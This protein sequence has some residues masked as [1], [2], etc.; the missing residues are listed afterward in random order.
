MDNYDLEN[1]YEIFG[2]DYKIKISPMNNQLYKNISTYINFANCERKLRENPKYSSSNFS[3]FQIELSNLYESSLINEVEY[4]VFNEKRENID[5]SVCKDEKIEINYEI[6]NT[7][8]INISKINYYSEQGIDIF[9]SKHQFFNDI[10]YPYSEEDSDIILQ[11]RI[12]DIYENYSLC[13]KNCNY[14]GINTTLNT[15]KC[16][17]SV[18]T[19]TDTT[20]EEPKLNEIIIG[21]FTKSNIG[22]IKCYNLVFNI[23]NKINNIGFWIY[24][25][26][27][28]LH[29]PTFVYYIVYNITSIKKYIS[30]ELKKFN[31]VSVD[32]N[33]KKDKKSRDKKSHAPK[34]LKK[35]K[36]NDINLYDK[37]NKQKNKYKANISSISDL[38][39][40]LSS[41][42]MNNLKSKSRKGRD[43]LIINENDKKRKK[44]EKEKNKNKKDIKNPSLVLDF[45]VTNKNYIN[46]IKNKEKNKEKINDKKKDK[47][48]EK[49]NTNFETKNPNNPQKIKFSSKNYYLIQ[50]DADNTTSIVPPN[51][52]FI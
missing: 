42:K 35:I 14:E 34:K 9:N 5:L 39:Y 37:R 3:I 43:K 47:N 11:D 4:A 52:T 40:N 12:T 6:K 16:E 13:E 33:K 38:N 46:I 19:Y 17:C 15:I 21:T 32:P 41:E 51:S 18:K 36:S 45:K 28:L 2:D 29:I 7:S 50:M 24:T 20:V 49:E 27:V 10:C 23:K 48:K 1:I 31:Y 22:V 25:I 44:K 30:N 8:L 26:L